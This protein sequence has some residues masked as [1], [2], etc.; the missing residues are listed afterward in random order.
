MAT[1]LA[2]SYVNY[3]P[4]FAASSHG[5]IL[6]ATGTAYDVHRQVYVNVALTLAGTADGKL[7]TVIHL[8]G[9]GGDVSVQDYTIFSVSKGVG[10]LVMPSHYI[11]LIIW[12]TPRYGGR[13]ALWPMI[14]RTGTLSGQTVP[15]SLYSNHV[16]LP[17]QGTPRLDSLS[18]QGTI[19]PIY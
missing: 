5:F 12:V 16:I 6:S 8:S 7:K 10:E 14:G 11:V 18:L 9:M 19:T 1:V 15:F 17:I 2:A 3:V 4:V 13:I